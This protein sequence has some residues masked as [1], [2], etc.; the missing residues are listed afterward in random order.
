MGLTLPS[1]RRWSDPSPAR[2]ARPRRVRRLQPEVLGAHLES[3]QL[4]A[5]GLDPTFGIGGTAVVPLIQ[6]PDANTQQFINVT[7]SAVQSDGKIVVAGVLFRTVS[8]GNPPTFT[9]S[10]DL[11]V[12]R[13]TPEGT[14]DPTFGVGG[15]T[16]IAANVNN[17]RWDVE[18]PAR[19]DLT[20]DGRVVVGATI[21]DPTPQNTNDTRFVV[22][23]LTAAGALDNSFNGVGFQTVAFSSN[24]RL[25]DVTVLPNNKVAAVGDLDVLNPPPGGGARDFAVAQ[26]TDAGAPDNSFDGDGKREFNVIL[27]GGVPSEDNA[28]AIEA[29]ADNKLV[30]A[31][32][33]GIP[34]AATG[35]DVVL[36]RLNPDGAF[37]STFDGDGILA[38]P[39]NLGGNNNDTASELAIAPD[40]KIVVVGNAVLTSPAANSFL[41]TTIRQALAARVNTNGTLD[42][43]FDG[44]GKVTIPIN[45]PGIAFSTTADSVSLLSNGNILLS[46]SANGFGQFAGTLA[47]LTNAGA[48]DTSFGPGGIVLLP[49]GTAR[50]AALLPD[51]K[52]VFLGGNQVFRTTAPT[53]VVVQATATTT[54][55][56]NRRGS[57]RVTGA[58][59]RFN[60]TLNPALANNVNAYTVR[61]GRRVLRVRS[62]TYDGAT[63]TVSIVLRQKFRTN[64]PLSITINGAGIVDRDGQVL[65]NG[66][67]LTVDALLPVTSPIRGKKSR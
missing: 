50:D 43:T 28:A 57:I 32:D 14:L 58:Q 18:G 31:G 49:T 47:Q 3:R 13:F 60:T 15:R 36:V 19:V 10:S 45:V 26:L 38:I 39:Y 4:L 25:A 55:T 67:P 48:L 27:T 63:N 5:T 65:N 52:V 53:P 22:A 6:N 8:T 61:S 7:Q 54:G 33:A 56:A 51:G 62:V 42:T 1:L 12:A 46:G 40:G 66:Q 30:I 16:T 21:N 17:T 35:T 34:N 24:A 41:Q 23:R 37:D 64:K 20:A 29:Q 44:D 9:N 11:V 2:A 59:I